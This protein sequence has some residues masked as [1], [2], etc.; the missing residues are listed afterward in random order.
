[1]V[2]QFITR[3]V[4]PVGNI[5]PLVLGLTRWAVLTWCLTIQPQEHLSDSIIPLNPLMFSWVP[6]SILISPFLNL[7]MRYFYI[8][9]YRLSKNGVLAAEPLWM[10]KKMRGKNG[11]RPRAV[12]WATPTSTQNL[13]E[14]EWVTEGSWVVGS[15]FGL[16]TKVTAWELN[17]EFRLH[18]AH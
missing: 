15:G 5:C 1:M 17:W 9:F 4:Q 14:T 12:S 2:L 6:P 10:K 11:S 8:L 3:M 16:D 7:G 13:G 18:G